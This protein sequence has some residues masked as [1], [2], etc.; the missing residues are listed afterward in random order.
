M[1][2]EQQKRAWD[3]NGYHYEICKFKHDRAINIFQNG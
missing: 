2:A 1:K 3:P